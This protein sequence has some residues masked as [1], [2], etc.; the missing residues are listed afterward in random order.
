MRGT[1]PIPYLLC[2]NASSFRVTLEGTSTQTATMSHPRPLAMATDASQ[3]GVQLGS[4]SS[5]AAWFLPDVTV[6]ESARVV[7]ALLRSLRRCCRPTEQGLFRKGIGSLNAERLE[8]PRA[9][10][11]K[12]LCA[13]GSAS[14]GMT[15]ANGPTC[16]QLVTITPQNRANRLSDNARRVVRQIW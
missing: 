9:G 8:T 5:H 2:S 15:N 12:P 10:A 1:G 16:L 13:R 6:R 7:H 4:L 11:S 14:R 3:G